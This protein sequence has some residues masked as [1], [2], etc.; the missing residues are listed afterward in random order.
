MP[1]DHLAKPADFWGVMDNELHAS[2]TW[3][4]TVPV[5]V[6]APVTGPMVLTREVRY[7]DRDG[8]PEA[9]E[10]F[11]RIGGVV[12]KKGDPEAP[13]AG[14]TVRVAGTGSEAQTGRDGRYV[15]PFVPAGKVTLRVERSG[16]KAVE[17]EVVVPSEGYDIEV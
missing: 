12:H 9:Y 1:P 16:E 10:A 11:I 6:F 5:D 3:V 15:L 2:L 7:R 14:A 13:V 8:A 17:R 4:A